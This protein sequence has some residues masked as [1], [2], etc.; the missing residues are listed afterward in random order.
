MHGGLTVVPN[1]NL[2]ENIGF[3]S[4]A[5]NTTNEGGWIAGRRAEPIG[6]LTHPATVCADPQH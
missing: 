1:V 5:T 4:G 6:S 2:V 3:G